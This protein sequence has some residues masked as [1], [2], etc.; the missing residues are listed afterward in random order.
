MANGEDCR[1]DWR[2]LATGNGEP[3]TMRGLQSSEDRDKYG[4]NGAGAEII[5]KE[6]FQMVLIYGSK[7]WVVMGDMFKNL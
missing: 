3:L 2:L 1:G 7:S 5:Y 6:F 4:R